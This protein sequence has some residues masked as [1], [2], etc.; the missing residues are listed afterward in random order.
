M[1]SDRN[2]TFAAVRRAIIRVLKVPEDQVLEGRNIRELRNV[3]SMALMEVVALAEGDLGIDIDVGS[4]FD[5]QTVGQFVDV[6]HQL[7]V[8][9][10]A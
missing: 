4:L 3:D 5:I 8:S 7:V 6:C 1:V 10:A 2:Q 9:R